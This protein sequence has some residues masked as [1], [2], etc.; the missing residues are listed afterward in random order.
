M[1]ANL[2]ERSHTL[3]HAFLGDKNRAF[4]EHRSTIFLLGNLKIV[5]ILK[6]DFIDNLQNKCLQ[7]KFKY[8]DLIKL[9][10]KIFS[11]HNFFFVFRI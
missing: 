1:Q 7:A 3:L 4:S 11:H 5:D 6:K 2:C 10:F 8:V 9:C